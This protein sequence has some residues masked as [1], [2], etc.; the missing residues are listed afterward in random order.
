MIKS[1]EKG[2]SLHLL[3][4]LFLSK[5]NSPSKQ[6]NLL[7][8][9]LEVGSSFLWGGIRK[10]IKVNSW[11]FSISTFW[12]F[13]VTEQFRTL[14][15]KKMNH[16]ERLLVRFSIIVFY[17]GVW[18]PFACFFLQMDMIWYYQIC[19]NATTVNQPSMVIAGT[20]FLSLSLF[21]GCRCW[22]PNQLIDT[23]SRQGF[24]K[25]RLLPCFFK[26]LLRLLRW[27]QPTGCFN[28]EDID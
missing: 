12:A 7:R 28:T 13:P 20:K 9:H 19:T 24:N 11:L 14:S 17:T 27:V 23:S 1:A 15:V 18:N 5:S 21:H 10:Q 26:H 6:W 2:L 3:S 16:I 8:N 22:K 25:L 4:Q